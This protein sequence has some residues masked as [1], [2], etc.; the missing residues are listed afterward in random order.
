MHRYV[1]R[2]RSA[3]LRELTE[4]LDLFRIEA[5]NLDALA[6]LDPGHHAGERVVQYAGEAQAQRVVRGTL[7]L[8][9]LRVAACGHALSHGVGDRQR[10]GARQHDWSSRSRVT[11]RACR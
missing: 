7:A 8:G 6:L 11:E 4:L 5:A 9:R 2:E 1:R 10:L 3:H